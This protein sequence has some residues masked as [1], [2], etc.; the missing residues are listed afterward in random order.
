MDA[1][2]DDDPY[3]STFRLGK[4]SSP[5]TVAAVQARPADILPTNPSRFPLIKHM[6]NAGMAKQSMVPVGVVPELKFMFSLIWSMEDQVPMIS[7]KTHRLLLI[8]RL[9]F[10]AVYSP[11][12]LLSSPTMRSSYTYTCLFPI[13]PAPRLVKN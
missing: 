12:E 9:V 13:K 6:R 4:Y 7:A 1:L 2:L 3:R 10:D 8:L 11:L 5:S